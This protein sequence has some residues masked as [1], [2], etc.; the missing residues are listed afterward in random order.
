MKEERECSSV[1]HVTKTNQDEAMNSVNH[2]HKVRYKNYINKK[3]IM[4]LE[5]RID[6]P[7]LDNH[8]FPPSARSCSKWKW[9]GPDMRGTKMITV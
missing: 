3:Q 5:Y 9:I 2:F 7:F 8:V 4:L 6:D 1:L